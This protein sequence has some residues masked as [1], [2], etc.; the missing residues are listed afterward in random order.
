MQATGTDV[1]E[2]CR[3]QVLKLLRLEQYSFV[4]LV[5]DTVSCKS[6]IGQVRCVESSNF[7][8]IFTN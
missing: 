4:Q 7:D 6:Q 2:V 3:Q 8:E 5:P 1:T